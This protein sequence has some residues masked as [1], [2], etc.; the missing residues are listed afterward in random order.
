MHMPNQVSDDVIKAFNDMKLNR[1][2]RYLSVAIKDKKEIFLE[3][4]SSREGMSECAVV[5]QPGVF[6]FVLNHFPRHMR[7]LSCESSKDVPFE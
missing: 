7:I 3:K 6:C 5:S 2:H 1:T 4:A